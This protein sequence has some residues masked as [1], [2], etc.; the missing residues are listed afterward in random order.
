MDNQIAE[1]RLTQ[2]DRDR[3]RFLTGEG[4]YLADI[5]A[6]D[7]LSA[8][9]LRSP[10]AH[11]EIT[12]IDLARA[13]AMPGVA[14]ILTGA[15]CAAAGF[16]NFRGL[17]RYGA[18]GPRPLVVPH[19][20]VLALDR[21]RHVGEPVACVIAASPEAALDAAEAIEITYRTLPPVIGFDAAGPA[22][23]PEA[24]DN[25]AFDF[26]TGDADAVRDAFASAAHQVET[27]IEL[28]RLAPSAM[29]PRGVIARFNAASGVY[30]LI[31]PHQGINEIR[32]DLAAILGVPTEAI[33]IELPDV[34]GA[35]GARSPAY[36]EHA[37]LLLAARL[38]G[39]TV[40]WVASR[41]EAFLTD[42]YGRST[43]LTGHLALDQ[44]GRFLALD[45]HFEADLGAYVTTVGAFVNVHN[46]M[47]TIT[48][49]YVIPAI[50]ARFTQYFTNTGPIA[51]YRGAGRPDMA[52][53]IE[54]LV[55]RA[56]AVIGTGPL[57]LRAL[58][59][60]P[61]DAFPYRTPL[62]AVY[63]SADYAA[64][65][66]AARKAADWDGFG[67]RCA[68][69]L[70]R[71]KLLGH[72]AALFTE[73]AG[74]GATDRDEARVTLAAGQGRA[75]ARIETVTGGSGQSQAETYAFI[76]AAK[77][78]LDPADIRL[79]ASPADTRLAG[80]GSIASRSTISAGSAIADAGDQLRARL[81]I[82]AGLR[83]NAP[84]EELLITAGEITRADGSRVM[85][86]AEAINALDGPATALGSAPL[87]MSFPSGCHI[88]EIEIDQD[89]GHAML[90]R[91]V[92]VD[93]AGVILNPIA[94]EGQI[95]G[96]IV[97]GLGEV[98]GE[99][100]RYDETGQPVTGSFMDYTMPRADDVPSFIVDERPTA[101]PHNRLGAKG[102]GE[103]GTTGG[104]AAAANA[105]AD[106]LARIGVEL[107]QLPCTPERLWQA[108]H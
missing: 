19:R 52:L 101:S 64:L 48:G 28:P 67:V 78:G 89:T 70:T 40:R 62:G 51:A 81:L 75:T 93:D 96:G 21:V 50:A 82:I 55:D 36:P 29:E 83:A 57:E 20:P 8:A 3:T 39:R 38:T 88:A 103:A 79:D 65:I 6:P 73:V 80:A 58:N 49:T 33:L 25:L 17:M 107:P 32:L 99:A 30:H 108:L 35:F 10:H 46:P 26:A 24:P 77:L 102:L 60:I 85:T 71:G 18:T 76:L 53:L 41:S 44:A 66:E 9:F 22:I 61:R 37:A 98:F 74:G 92:A 56:A 12:Q 97:Q 7:A 4:R 13:R 45:V 23:Y 5:T 42:C 87:S 100:M 104:L 105:V 14:A 91:Y 15:D 63:D 47:Q 2:S 1:R 43:R 34:G 54:R 27:T 11:A 90:T 106:A 94:A 68:G 31:T 72:G 69:A 59:A 86:L 16:G 95:H 84:P